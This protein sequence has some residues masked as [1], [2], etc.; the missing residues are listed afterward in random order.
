VPPLLVALAA[1]AATFRATA[2]CTALILAAEAMI[3]ALVLTLAS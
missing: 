2:I 1:L 3:F